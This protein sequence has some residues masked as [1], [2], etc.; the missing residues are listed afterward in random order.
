MNRVQSL[1]TAVER[2]HKYE[3]YNIFGGRNSRYSISI[4]YLIRIRNDNNSTGSNEDGGSLHV[5]RHSL[6]G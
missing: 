2:T 5:G 3:G 6:E 4:L 1:R